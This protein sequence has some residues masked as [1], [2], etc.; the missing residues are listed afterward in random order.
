MWLF[1][2]LRPTAA[3]GLA[4][5]TNIPLK[6]PQKK[7]PT[8]VPEKV[9]RWGKQIW[10]L[11]GVGLQ[12]M[13][14]PQILSR[15]RKTLIFLPPRD[16]VCYQPQMN[17]TRKCLWPKRTA[18]YSW[19]LGRMYWLCPCEV[20]QAG[21]WP[22]FKNWT[23]WRGIQAPQTPLGSVSSVWLQ[24][25]SITL[26][27]ICSSPSLAGVIPGDQY[28]TNFLSIPL[29]SLFPSENWPPTSQNGERSSSSNMNVFFRAT[30]T[31]VKIIA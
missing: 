4:H 7:R 17:P 8:R 9:S 1:V 30:A 11:K 16:V 10:G 21:T 14:N 5:S 19:E 20:Q 12:W 31:E 2:V 26:C 29:G 22:Q 25:R 3:M 24:G 6:F 15:P 28:P 27:P 13:L 18:H 23:F